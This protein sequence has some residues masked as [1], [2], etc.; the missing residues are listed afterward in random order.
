MLE[1]IKSSF[2]IKMMFNYQIK[3]ITLKLIKYNKNLKN[4]IG[5][6]ID[7]YKKYSKR[8]IIYESKTIGKEY[9]CH[10]NNEILIYEGEYLNSKEMEK[11][12]NIMMMV[13]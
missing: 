10:L 13:N 2:F 3:G 1:R 11:E 9:Y 12:K 4:I 5:I 6:N 8:Y 7:D